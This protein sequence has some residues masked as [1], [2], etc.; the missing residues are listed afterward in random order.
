MA[1]LTPKAMFLTWW[2]ASAAYVHLRGTVR[3]RPFRQLTDHSTLLAPINALLYLGSAVPNRPYLPVED[4]PGLA[5]LR[6]HWEAIREEA[7]ALYDAGHI[8]AAGDYNDAGFN[9]FFKTGWKR[10]YLKWYDVS[11]PSAT[12]LCPTTVA[13]LKDIPEV[14][15][16]MFASLPPGGRLV[17]HRDPY[18]GSLRYHLG[19]IT[20]NDDG[21]RIIVDGQPYA[22]RDGEAVMFDETFIHYAE[23]TTDQ[24]R[25]IL[26]C[27]VE[28]PLRH[29]WL[30]AVNRWF[31]RHVM[32]AA[33]S[34]NNDDDHTGGINRAFR[35]LYRVRLQG[36]RLKQ[37][38]RTL[39]Y[40]VKWLLILA[41]AALLYSL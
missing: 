16:A 10:F 38:N 28:R 13:L 34:P 39:Y 29:R 2:A 19:L 20:P 23:N 18:A 14:K 37:R 9:S 36:K 25:I 15:A 33:A 35:H 6:E 27:D 22:W 24:P 4:F 3:H 41:V 1:L 7:R 40:A 32:S 5:P 26:F 31:S 11:H 30:Q 17:R 12:E 21:C 8:R